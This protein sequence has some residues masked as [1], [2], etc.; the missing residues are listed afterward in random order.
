[1][2]EKIRLGHGLAI[3]R[4]MDRP[5]A[6]K[7]LSLALLLVGVCFSYSAEAKKKPRRLVAVSPV[8]RAHA[9]NDDFFDAPN[10]TSDVVTPAATTVASAPSA[11]P[12]SQLVDLPDEQTE[13]V[14]ILNGTCPFADGRCNDSAKASML[15]IDVT[16]MD[17][18]ADAA[19][20]PPPVDPVANKSPSTP[21]AA[22]YAHRVSQ[23]AFAAASRCR[24]FARFRK[25]RMHLNPKKTY[26]SCKFFGK[27]NAF[28]SKSLC[29][30]A[31]QEA[32]RE[33]GIYLPRGDAISQKRNLARAGLVRVPYDPYKV[34]AG[35]V[36]VCSGGHG[37]NYGDIQIV[38][39]DKNGTR[40]FCSDFC[41]A[42]PVCSDAWH[43]SPQAYKFPGS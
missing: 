33:A 34:P 14:A 3:Y 26:N 31:V 5:V 30:T 21:A 8:H 15:K 38:S 41:S 27:Q 7:Q 4:D 12:A 32:L 37:H 43:R 17:E 24:D 23:A 40:R 16:L 1:L 25:K 36:L 22:S 9:A 10:V 18:A 39:V 19:I 29:S 6:F 2:L 13:G 20:P 11:P 35:T 28:H 42:R